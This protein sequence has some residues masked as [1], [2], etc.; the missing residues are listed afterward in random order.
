MRSYFAFAH[1][2]TSGLNY[3]R[4]MVPNGDF[5]VTYLPRPDLFDR[6]EG[7]WKVPEQISCGW[8]P[9]QA[10]QQE[11]EEPLGWWE[12]THQAHV[13]DQGWFNPNQ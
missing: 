7:K 3:Y 1:N 5:T 2:Y 9:Q 10:Q 11:A 12:L 8:E 6:I 13:P 4:Y